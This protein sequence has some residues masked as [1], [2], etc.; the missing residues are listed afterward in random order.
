[1]L[2]LRPAIAGRLTLV[3]GGAVAHQVVALDDDDLVLATPGE[4]TAEP[5]S[6]LGTAPLA[7]IDLRLPRPAPSWPRAPRLTRG[8][9]SP[10]TN[11]GP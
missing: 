11:G 5:L 7:D 3:P 2:A 4:R 6:N 1:M 9:P 10:S 8:T